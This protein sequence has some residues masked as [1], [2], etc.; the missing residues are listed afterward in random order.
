MASGRQL[1]KLVHAPASKASGQRNYILADGKSSSSSAVGGMKLRL[2]RSL[3]SVEAI[4]TACD[5]NF[6]PGSA[7]SLP[8]SPSTMT[9]HL[10]LHRIKC[11]PLLSCLHGSFSVKIAL[12]GQICQ[13][14]PIKQLA[15]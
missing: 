11:K 1:Q 2:L 14:Q 12:S 6:F 4:T 8:G 3:C 13:G 9:L 10:T 5:C 7:D 15:D